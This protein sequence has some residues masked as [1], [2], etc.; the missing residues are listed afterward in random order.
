M[1]GRGRGHTQTEIAAEAW[2]ATA[3]AS[4]PEPVGA[5]VS[6]LCP[7][8]VSSPSER[9]AWSWL[10]WG[11]TR[12]HMCVGVCSHSCV[13]SSCG[14]HNLWAEQ[15]ATALLPALGPGPLDA[16][17][18]VAFPSPGHSAS[19][20]PNQEPERS[21]DVLAQEACPARGVCVRVHLSLSVGVQGLYFQ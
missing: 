13:Q 6:L 16:H 12:P 20:G 10:P 2:E 21:L 18:S 3:S 7:F 11:G 19:P 5:A 8:A 9:K 15:S 1:Q 14:G 17:S 4:L